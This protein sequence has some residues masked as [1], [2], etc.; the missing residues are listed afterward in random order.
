[1]DGGRLQ[2][3]ESQFQKDLAEIF[4]ELTQDQFRGLLLTP[5]HV[6]ITPDLSIARIQV[7]VFPAKNKE[8]LVDWLNNH[9]GMIKDHLVKKF[10]GQ[11]RKM[12]ELHFYLDD[13][14]D[15]QEELDKILRGGGESPIK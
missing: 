2:R 4:R 13:S 9:E 12:P 11:L 10:K 5:S 15:Q 3:V 14:L 6:R 7:S 8:D 1:M